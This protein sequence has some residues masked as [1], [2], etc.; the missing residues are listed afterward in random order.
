M[1]NPFKFGKVVEGEDFCN[2]QEEVKYLKHQIRSNHSVWLYSPRRFGKTSLLKKVYGEIDA[3]KTIYFDLYNIQSIDDFAKK[4][5]NIL[6]AELFNWKADIRRISKQLGSYFTRLYPKVSLDEQGNPTFELGLY[7]IHEQ[8]DIETI[9][10]IPEKIGLKNKQ[11]ICIA[12]D[13]F[14]EIA[15]VEPF[16]VNWMRSAFQTQKMVSYIFLGSQKSLMQSIFADAKSP[17]YEFGMKMKIHPI[18]KRDLAEFI[19]RKFEATALAISPEHIGTILGKS[20]CHPHFTQYFASV[21]WD[22]IFE[23]SNQSNPE[24]T[25]RWIN[26]I[27][28]SQ[29]I[30]FQTIYD[31]LNINQKKVL[32]ALTMSDQEVAIFSTSTANEYNLP[33]SSTV[34]EA[35]KSLLNKDLIYKKGKTYMLSNP[36]FKEWLRSL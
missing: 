11:R 9:L 33:A 34:H 4:Y 18:S 23:G 29:S 7:P 19:Q 15:R 27:I 3:I 8:N 17:L 24:F 13:E 12:F 36:V 10:N 20:E 2:R 6:A 16:L 21:V 22:F 35:I 26:R 1:E 5:S 30:V 32:K 28:E 31:Q 25:T 14:Q